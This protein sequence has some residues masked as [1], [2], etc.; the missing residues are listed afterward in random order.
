MDGIDAVLLE[1]DGSENCIRELGYSA[2]TYDPDFKILLKSV[3]YAIRNSQGQ[4]EKAK[5][6]YNQAL[7]EYLI[8]E[9]KLTGIQ[10]ENIYLKL[11]AYFLTHEYP[12]AV[13]DLETVL[14]H[15]TRLHAQAVKR[16]LS[17]TGYRPE[18]ID[19][20]GYHGQTMYHQPNQG[21]SIVVGD[22]QF[23][24]DEI[25]ITVVNDFRS[26]DVRAGGQGAPFAPI[27]HQSLAIRDHKIPVA[28][29]NC[30]GISNITLV[31]T[32][33]PLDLMAFDTGPGNG[34]IDRLV[35]QRTRGQEHMDANGQY[36]KKGKVQPDIL[37]ALY[38]KSLLKGQ[39]NYF[40]IK[41]PKSLDIGD[42][43]LIPE[44]DA[45]SLED[46]CATLEFFTADSI[47]KSLEWVQK[48]VPM[49]WILAGGGWNNPVIRDELENR[50]VQKFGN[51]VQ[52]L[53]A[54]EA[55]W[56]SQ[57]LEAQI[58]AYFAV[59]SLQNKPLS[60]PGTTHVPKPI[61]GGHAYVPK[62]GATLVVQSL[63]KENPGVLSG[64][65][66]S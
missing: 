50:L 28:I 3:E 16:L 62:K 38:T 27:Y 23:L 24:A 37:Q 30:G 39:E 47:V 31:L 17:Q 21:I 18:Q 64:Y 41:P 8:K 54:E 52:I 48:E 55:G 7:E 2:L 36:G 4:M 19:V 63:L 42:L 51:Q 43:A 25:G 60:V 57:G 53:T 61:S 32:S 58:F 44:L 35:R 1:T 66:L 12:E 45:L 29:V 5:N 34:L 40:S 33:D 9:L 59:R 10:K 15:S 49:N 46:A 22:G 26:N 6:Y 65:K 14:R 11:K 13:L 56:D 20:V